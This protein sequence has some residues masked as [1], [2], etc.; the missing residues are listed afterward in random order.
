M[1]RDKTIVELLHELT[2]AGKVVT[3]SNDFSGMMT[4]AIDEDHAHLNYP[5]GPLKDLEREL[6]TYLGS[7]V[8]KE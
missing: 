5:H 7:A 8:N 1:A 4:V 6:V 3:F 2:Q